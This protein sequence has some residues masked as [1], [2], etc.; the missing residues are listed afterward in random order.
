VILGRKIGVVLR[1]EKRH[2]EGKL[3]E[4]KKIVMDDVMGCSWGD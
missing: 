4:E 2:F 1:Y 3:W